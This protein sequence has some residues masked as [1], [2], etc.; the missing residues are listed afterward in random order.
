MYVTAWSNGGTGYGLEIRESDRDRYFDPAWRSVILDLP[1]RGRV[2]VR[3]SPSFWRGCRELRSAEIGRWLHEHNLAP[4]SR[5][6]RP[7]VV[8]E[9]V[10]GNHF[11][12]RSPSST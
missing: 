12:V 1:G 2:D 7:R 5:G 6:R 4:W 9:H 8:M 11:V 3:V 10:T